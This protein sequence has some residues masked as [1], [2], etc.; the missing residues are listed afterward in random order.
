MYTN[1][2]PASLSKGT[3][4]EQM[5]PGFPGVGVVE[6]TIKTIFHMPILMI[7]QVQ[8]V[9]SIMERSQQK[10]LSLGSILDFQ[11]A[12][13]VSSEHMMAKQNL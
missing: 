8:C 10:T 7:Q 13:Q 6:H 11:I 9:E 2:F 5:V 1:N 12:L 3:Q 4:K